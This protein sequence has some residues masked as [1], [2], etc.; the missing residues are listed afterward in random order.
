MNSMTMTSRLVSVATLLLCASAAVAGPISVV[1]FSFETLPLAGLPTHCAF[2]GCLFGGGPIPGWSNTAGAVAEFQ[3]GN[4]ANTHYFNNPLPDGP[5]VAASSGPIIFQPVGPTVQTGV[6]YTL[7][8]DLGRRADQGLPFT[9][10]A[11]LLIN[12]H[13]ISAIGV[14]PG[15]GN[16]SNFTA[17]YT[18]LAAD[19]GDSITIQLRSSG[20]QAEFDNVRLSDSTVASVPE[21][22][23]VTLLGLGLASFLIFARRK[24]TS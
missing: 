15:A 21:P 2:A 5:T 7:M 16:F 11:D 13:I 14:T 12:G 23:S 17:T 3:P 20:V 8:V 22:A 19:A 4:P 1:N 9:A 18:G 6:V 24:R 10:S